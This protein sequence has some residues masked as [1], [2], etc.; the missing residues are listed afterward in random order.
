MTARHIP[1]DHTEDMS[2]ILDSV[3]VP[4]MPHRG[5]AHNKRPLNTFTT[6]KNAEYEPLEINE[7]QE[8]CQMGK[9]QETEKL[10]SQN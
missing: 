7:K 5:H 10:R 4:T 6:T 1:T 2:E 9:N 8:Q 3:D